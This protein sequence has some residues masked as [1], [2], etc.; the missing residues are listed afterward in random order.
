MALNSSH[1]KLRNRKDDCFDVDFAVSLQS[2]YPWKCKIT[3]EKQNGSELKV[4]HTWCQEYNRGDNQGADNE[5]N[6]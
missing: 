6:K 4:I 5:D 3:E 2:L 1:I